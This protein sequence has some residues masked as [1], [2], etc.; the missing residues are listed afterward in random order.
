MNTITL[1]GTEYELS[2][3]NLNMMVRM[4]ERWECDL[5][6]LGDMMTKKLNKEGAKTLRF[7]ISAFLI[8]QYADMDEK[9]VGSLIDASNMDHCVEV[10]TAAVNG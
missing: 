2:T 7:I 6:K 3:M 10:L 4:Q 1:G 9:K 5:D 8:D